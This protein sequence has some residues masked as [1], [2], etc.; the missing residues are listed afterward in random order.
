MAFGH[1]PRLS[2][3]L[4][5]SLRPSDSVQGLVWGSINTPEVCLILAPSYV[6]NPFAKL[7]DAAKALSKAAIKANPEVKDAKGHEGV[8]R[9]AQS[10]KGVKVCPLC[11]FLPVYLCTLHTLPL[12]PLEGCFCLRPCL[13][14]LL[15]WLPQILHKP[16]P[17]MVP[18][19]CPRLHP[20]PFLRPWPRQFQ[21]PKAAPG[22]GGGLV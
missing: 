21:G 15:S 10:T 13:R 9:S 2:G 22:G 1:G 3:A 18:R 7:K 12:H 4:G 19:P 16:C 17:I 8:Q 14:P 5:H 20:R 11:A 6:M